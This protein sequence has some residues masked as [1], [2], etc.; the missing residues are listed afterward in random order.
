MP[1]Q[2]LGF[3]E[4]RLVPFL[5]CQ[6]SAPTEVRVYGFVIVPAS[7]CVALPIRNLRYPYECGLVRNPRL[8]DRDWELIDKEGL[9]VATRYSAPLSL[10]PRSVS[11]PRPL[12][13]Y[14]LSHL[15]PKTLSI[16]VVTFLS[17]QAWAGTRR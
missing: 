14:V 13:L 11:P 9:A 10:G 1:P 4:Q 8:G 5:V 12:P 17:P 16:P 2:R 3:P 15:R 7:R 6:P